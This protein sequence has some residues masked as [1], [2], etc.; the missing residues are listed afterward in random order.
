VF[1]VPCYDDEG[2]EDEL[3]AYK[4]HSLIKCLHP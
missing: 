2:D 4:V 1:M 3:V